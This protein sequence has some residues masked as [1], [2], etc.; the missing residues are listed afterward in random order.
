MSAANDSSEVKRI[1]TG[2][3]GLDGLLQGGFL[4]NRSYVVAGDA[5]S[6]K[7]IA[8][9]QFVLAG[10]DR[11][12]TA[13]YVTVDERP[14]D[15]LQTA[16]SLGLNLATY[17]QEKKLAIL[18]ASLYFTGR[19]A[20][21]GEKGVDLSRFVTDLAD[22]A[23]KL[24]PT[25]LTIDPLTPLII[26]KDASVHPQEN[27]RTLFHLLQTQLATTNLLT[28]HLQNGLNDSASSAIEQFI[29]AGV[30]ILSQHRT[31]YSVVRTLE[32][33]KM[34]GTAVEPG[35]YQFRIAALQGITLVAAGGAVSSDPAPRRTLQ[36]FELPE[37]GL[38]QQR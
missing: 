16:L 11:G 7:T 28:A 17:I 27:A 14:A 25:R 12:E 23:N 8:C 6:G 35:E 18:D 29:S 24:K 32:I 38:T 36:S 1:S 2:I 10:L 19:A 9:M 21:V 33:K 13:V 30:I 26:S 5:G 3:T 4:P 22:Y 34:R 20:G 37:T 31:Q 15:I